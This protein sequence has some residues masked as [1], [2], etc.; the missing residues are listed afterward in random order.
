MAR[1]HVH[2]RMHVARGSG[3][4]APARCVSPLA[5]GAQQS[6]RNWCMP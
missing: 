3:L 1:A 5:V 2:T 6:S 4:V